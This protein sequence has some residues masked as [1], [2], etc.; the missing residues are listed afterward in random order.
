[1]E[2]MDVPVTVDFRKSGEQALEAHIELQLSEA[3]CD[4]ET[5]LDFR[6][7]P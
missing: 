4:A 1:M 2:W 6:E 7:L 5:P 3:T